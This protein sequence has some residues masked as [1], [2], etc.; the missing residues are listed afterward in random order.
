MNER[1]PNGPDGVRDRDRIHPTGRVRHRN[2]GGGR[3]V[4]GVPGEV[5]AA[6]DGRRA[7]RTY[8]W[9]ADGRA[10]GGRHGR[11]APQRGRATRPT[12]RKGAATAAQG[13]RRSV[14]GARPRGG[15]PA[16]HWAPTAHRSPRPPWAAPTNVP[17]PPPPPT[18][19]GSSR[20]RPPLPTG[21]PE[22][23]GD[24]EGVRP[25]GSSWS[26]GVEVGAVEAVHGGVDAVGRG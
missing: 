10:P 17:T 15:Q 9:L 19:R 7:R 14:G 18:H 20:Y 1:R 8:G 21:Q 11:R 3:S 24:A 16:P 4:D 2:R 23:S 22:A 5:A 6:R 25:A 13:S 12:G 26:I